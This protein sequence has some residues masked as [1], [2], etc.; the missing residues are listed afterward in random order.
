MFAVDWTVL[1]LGAGLLTGLLGLAG[2]AVA[3][4]LLIFGDGGRH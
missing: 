2:A 1:F 4:Y 3:L